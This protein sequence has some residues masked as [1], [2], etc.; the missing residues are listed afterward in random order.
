MRCV[1]LFLVGAFCAVGTM[2]YIHELEI[3]A[4]RKELYPER[5]RKIYP[6]RPPEVAKCR[7]G[8]VV[9]YADAGPKLMRCV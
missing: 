7:D 8:W 3:D 2:D 5:A 9:S 4:L 1:I 6:D